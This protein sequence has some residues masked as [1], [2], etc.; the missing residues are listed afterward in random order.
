M[1][2]LLG[3]GDCGATEKLSAVLVASVGLVELA[4]RD[5]VRAPKVSART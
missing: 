2:Q 4:N 5:E 3:A 1:L